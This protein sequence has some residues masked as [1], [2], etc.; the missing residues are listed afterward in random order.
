MTALGKRNLVRVVSVFTILAV[1]PPLQLSENAVG[2]GISSL[3]AFTVGSLCESDDESKCFS[4]EQSCP[5]CEPLVYITYDMYCSDD[6]FN[7][8]DTCCP[9]VNTC[10]FRGYGEELHH[11]N[12]DSPCGDT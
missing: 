5:W 3:R 11:N 6:T 7:T 9:A 10:Y 4:I 2:F 1:A 8:C 12:G